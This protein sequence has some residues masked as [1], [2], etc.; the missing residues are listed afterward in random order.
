MVRFRALR[1]T[2]NVHVFDAIHASGGTD[3]VFY[4][5]IPPSAL[6][7]SYKVTVIHRILKV[8]FIVVFFRHAPLQI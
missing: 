7:V 5:T 3:S 1:P 8:G 6:F 4:V 2:A